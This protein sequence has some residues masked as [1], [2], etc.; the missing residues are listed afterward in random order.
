MSR[1]VEQIS[2]SSDGLAELDGSGRLRSSQVPDLAITE[3]FTAADD[4]ERYG[5]DVE[6]GDL[7]IQGDDTYV[8]TG[9]ETDNEDNW[10]T[11]RFDV[12]ITEVFGRTGDVAAKS[13]D[14]TFNQIDDREHDNSDHERDYYAAGDDA[15]FGDLEAT[16]RLRVP[17]VQTEDDLP[18]VEY[19]AIYYVDGEDEYYGSY[20]E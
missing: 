5:L 1:A 18:D 2:G 8:F 16:D 3:T 4:D 12:P 13:G 6:E 20:D 19:P 17:S 7:V 9:G 14:Y 10:S 15:S 11:I